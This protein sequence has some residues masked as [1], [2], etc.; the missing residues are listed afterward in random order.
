MKH[1][2]IYDS[3]F[4]IKPNLKNLTLEQII[5][6]DNRVSAM[7]SNLNGRGGVGAKVICDPVLTVR[8]YRH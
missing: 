8:G 5:D 6:T 7:R 1:H 4:T 3:V 2:L